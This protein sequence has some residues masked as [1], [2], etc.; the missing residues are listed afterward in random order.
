MALYQRLKHWQFYL[1]LVLFAGFG[2]TPNP[3]EILAQTNDLLLHFSGYTIAGI[4]MGLSKPALH[5]W[6]RFLF[7]WLYSLAI[8]VGQH[9]VP[10]R[11]FDLLDLVANGSG[12]ILGLILYQWLARPIDRALTRAIAPSQ[13]N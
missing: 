13:T 7:L 4:S 1:L 3:G 8:E 2:L 12:A 11:G 5:H 9:F 10:H 6:Q